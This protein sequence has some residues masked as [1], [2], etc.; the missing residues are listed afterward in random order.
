MRNLP[1]I[2]SYGKYSSDNY[3]MNTVRLSFSGIVLYY[4]YKTIVAYDDFT[5]NLVVREN[6]FSVT[7]GKHLNWINDNHYSRIPGDEF[8]IKLQA[9]LERQFKDQ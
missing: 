4:S 1:S 5:D 6:D 2:S 9:A 3:G 8:E 7:T